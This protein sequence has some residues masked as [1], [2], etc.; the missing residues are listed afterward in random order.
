MSEIWVPQTLSWFSPFQTDTVTCA[1]SP[2]QHPAAP[3]PC[4][5]AVCRVPGPLWTTEHSWRGA[6]G[7]LGRDPGPEDGNSSW[8]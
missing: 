7:R 8:V 6:Q 5:P 4:D 1:F 3:R 2:W